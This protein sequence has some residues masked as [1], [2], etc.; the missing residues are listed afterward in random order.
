MQLDSRTFLH[1]SGPTA[2]CKA[3]PVDKAVL[4]QPEAP[5]RQHAPPRKVTGVWHCAPDLHGWTFH[6]PKKIL[7]HALE[8]AGASAVDGFSESGLSYVGH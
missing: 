5:K 7:E 1:S 3:T 4:P 6:P 8:N 2:A